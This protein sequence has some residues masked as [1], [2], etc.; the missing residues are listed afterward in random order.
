[1]TDRRALAEEIIDLRS[2]AVATRPIDREDPDSGSALWMAGICRLAAWAWAPGRTQ[3]ERRRAVLQIAVIATAWVE[4][5]D[6]ELGGQA[7]P[8]TGPFAGPANTPTTEE[9]A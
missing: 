8:E 5:I 7:L 3:L 2:R 6:V 9:P 4:A 1:M